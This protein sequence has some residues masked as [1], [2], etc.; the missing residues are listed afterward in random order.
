MDGRILWPQLRWSSEKV[1]LVVP[2]G[3]EAPPQADSSFERCPMHNEKIHSLVAKMEISCR[4]MEN[5]FG[6][7]L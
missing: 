6:L 7:V 1:S 4:N 5:F 3:F 2:S